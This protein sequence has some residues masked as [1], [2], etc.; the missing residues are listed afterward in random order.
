MLA[1]LQVVVTG[2]VEYALVA[3]G[4][5]VLP[6]AVAPDVVVAPHAQVALPADG[7]GDHPVP[8]SH[9]VH[10][11]GH[12][13]HLVPVLNV[14]RHEPIPPLDLSL[15][16]ERAVAFLEVIIP[17]HL[18]VALPAEV[19]PAVAAAHLVAALGLRDRDLA[20]GALLGSLLYGGHGLDLV[21]ELHLPPP[22]LLPRHVAAAPPLPE[23][24]QLR[25]RADAG[26]PRV[27]GCHAER[28]EGVHAGLALRQAFTV[29][30]AWRLA[31]RAVAQIRHAVQRSLQHELLP[32]REG[33]L[34]QHPLEVLRAQGRLAG[35][36]GAGEHL[37]RA[38]LDMDGAVLPRA[39]LAEGMPA[40]RE[41]RELV[42]PLLLEADHAEVGAPPELGRSS[43]AVVVEDHHERVLGVQGG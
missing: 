29:L 38:L 10:P 41:A 30:D 5:E 34:L 24:A 6:A 18:L 23:D 3:G 7:A 27:V 15:V 16:E 26:H 39:L 28:A 21:D 9:G 8:V 17:I 43:L 22:L 2:T 31:P 11:H 40:P 36:L 12:L 42:A 19:A 25:L 14:I 37:H 1:V 4:A 13:H 35:G 20:L 32:A 33:L